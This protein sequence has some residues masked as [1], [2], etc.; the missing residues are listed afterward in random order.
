MPAEAKPRQGRKTRRVHVTLTHGQELAIRG[1][2]LFEMCDRRLATV[3]THWIKEG[4]M[5]DL[6]RVRRK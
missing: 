6:D 4:I 3:I 2:L 5:R 1:S